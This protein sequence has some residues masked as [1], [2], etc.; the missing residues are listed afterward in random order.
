MD[1]NNKL[2]TLALQLYSVDA[3]KFGDFITKSGINTPVYFDLRVIV[4]YPDIMVNVW[5]RVII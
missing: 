1:Y 2:E 5:H 3:V 4:S